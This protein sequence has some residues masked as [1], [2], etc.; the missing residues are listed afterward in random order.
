MA[1]STLAQPSQREVHRHPSVQVPTTSTPVLVPSRYLQRPSQHQ[2]MRGIPLLIS[3]V[4]ASA[5]SI[6]L[7]TPSLHPR[8]ADSRTSTFSRQAG[9]TR[10]PGQSGAPGESPLITT[11]NR[12]NTSPSCDL[13][14]LQPLPFQH[15]RHPQPFQRSQAPTVSL[16]MLAILVVHPAISIRP[17]EPPPTVSTPTPP[18]S[19]IRV[20]VRNLFPS[21]CSPIHTYG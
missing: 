7:G 15:Q 10:Q 20:H 14:R 12:L 18:A 1:V 3:P 19:P 16:A 5:L 2:S 4:P 6:S 21:A 17:S 11:P 9:T 8:W 13:F